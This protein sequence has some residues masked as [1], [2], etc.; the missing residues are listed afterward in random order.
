MRERFL[1]LSCRLDSGWFAL[2]R[3]RFYLRTL[4]WLVIPLRVHSVPREPYVSARRP[5]RLLR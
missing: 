3:P 4:C 2:A 1:S 5:L